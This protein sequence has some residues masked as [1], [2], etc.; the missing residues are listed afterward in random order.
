MHAYLRPAR[1]LAAFAALLFCLALPTTLLAGSPVAAPAESALLEDATKGI[2]IKIVIIIIIKKGVAEVTDIRL[3]E[4]G[5]PLAKN[6]ILAEAEVVNGK[7][8]LKALK[9]GF[10]GAAPTQL[11]FSKPF[12]LR[13]DVSS[14]LQP[15]SLIIKPG[16]FDYKADSLLQFDIQD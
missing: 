7:L 9:E 2:R 1:L 15:G 6:E 14:K 5:V 4:Q 8:H 11:G 16:R 10:D 12:T 3:A 13:T